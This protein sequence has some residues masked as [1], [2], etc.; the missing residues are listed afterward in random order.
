MSLQN[1][2]YTLFSVHISMCLTWKP[3][4]KIALYLVQQL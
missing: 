1:S 2:R 3:E 4:K